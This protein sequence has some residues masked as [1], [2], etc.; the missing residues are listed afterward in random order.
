MSTIFALL[1]TLAILVFAPTLAARVMQ[2]K[3]GLG[4]GALV[5]FV[6]LGVLQ[7][8]AQLAPFLGPLGDF[9]VIMLGIAGW[10]QVIRIVHGTDRA[11]TI[12]FMFWHVFFF[13]TFISLAS[14]II[15]VAW[16]WGG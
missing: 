11:E 3:G 8:V 7:L 13:L 9:L 5:G 15:D 6:S 10:Y 1:L 2:L 14:A 16:L 12:V 4:K